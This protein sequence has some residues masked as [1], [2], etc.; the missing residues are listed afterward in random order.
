MNGCKYS[1]QNT[2]K[3]NS[4]EY[5][6]DYIPWLSGIHSWNPKMIQH[7]KINVT[8]Y[9]NRMKKSH[10]NT[11]TDAEKAFDKIEHHF[12]IKTLNKLRT[13]DNK[14]HIITTYENT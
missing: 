4:A 13:E 11:S 14:F 2:S 6:K 3:P 9:I 1:Q 7:V 8:Y 12:I 10:I 5:Q